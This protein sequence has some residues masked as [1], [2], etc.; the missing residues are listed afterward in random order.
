MARPHI[1]LYTTDKFSFL[2]RQHAGKH[3]TNKENDNGSWSWEYE[4]AN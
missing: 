2:G 3:E 1:Q 4:M